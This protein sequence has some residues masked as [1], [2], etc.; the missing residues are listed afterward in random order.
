MS[1][2]SAD[3]S[4]RPAGVEDAEPI[5]GIQAAAWRTAYTELLPRELLDA[6]DSAEAVEQWRASVA[7]PPS[8]HHRVLVALAGGTPVGFAAVAPSEDADAEEEADAE[9]TALCV[10]PGHTGQGH[11]SR[12]VNAAVDHLRGG[13]FRRVRVWLSTHGRTDDDVRRFLAGAGWEPD[14]AQR[15]L[16]LYGDGTLV[17]AQQRLSATLDG[18]VP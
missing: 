13:G 14:G 16:D 15:S 11:G 1:D 7:A 17:V 18:P 8:P 9:L 2:L 6:L 10:A 3:V 5:A 4:V 12:L